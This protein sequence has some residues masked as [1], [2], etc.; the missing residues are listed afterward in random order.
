MSCSVELRVL[1]LRDAVEAGLVRED[2]DLARLARS[3]HLAFR[4][5][6]W[7]W[8]LGVLDTE[9]LEVQCQYS[10]S[11]S[12]L[13]ALSDDG[14]AQVLERVAALGAAAERPQ[15]RRSRKRAW[16][17]LR[18]GPVIHGDSRAGDSL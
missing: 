17:E 10:V 6:L 15:R 7:Q 2:R 11:V 13:A 3:L 4:W 1:A 14:R 9:D 18:Q 5:T 8:A 16:G 12:L